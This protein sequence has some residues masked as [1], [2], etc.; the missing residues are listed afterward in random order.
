[1][2]IFDYPYVIITVFVLC[3]VLVGGIGI[4]FA[5]KGVKTAK[6]QAEKDFI[7]IGKMEKEFKQLKKHS[8]E[9]C[10]LRFF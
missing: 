2:L 10:Y 9:R 4:Y 7:S 6:G 5:A 1:M 8:T 3:F